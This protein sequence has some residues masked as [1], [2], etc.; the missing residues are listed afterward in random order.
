MSN[1]HLHDLRAESACR[2]FEKTRDIRRVMHFLDHRSLEETQKY[3]DRLIGATEQENATIMA[4][5]EQCVANG[6]A[7]GSTVTDDTQRTTL[8]TTLAPFPS[9]KP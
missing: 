8:R 6:N 2:L 5:F 1:L 3:I 9:R 4:T 7:T